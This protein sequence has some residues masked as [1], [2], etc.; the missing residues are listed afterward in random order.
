MSDQS[1]GLAT[2]PGQPLDASGWK[3]Q[4]TLWDGVVLQLPLLPGVFATSGFTISAIGSLGAVLVMITMGIIALLSNFLFAEMAGMFP[5]KPGSLAMYAREG[6]RRYFVP[7]GVLGGFGYWLGYV[8]SVSY[9]ALQFGVLIQFQWFPKST[10][11]VNFVGGV[12][13]GLQHFIA[14]GIIVVA[15][16]LALFD[17]K[18]MARLSTW[19]GIVALI[20]VL[21]IM[22][23]PWV[24]GQAHVSEWTM[25]IGGWKS[26]V[27]WLYIAGATLFAS[28]LGAAFAP[29]YKNPKKD[30]PRV[31]MFSAIFILI[32]Y[33]LA[34]ISASA[35][36]G[37]KTITAN[38]LNFAPI[39]AAQALGGG[40]AIFTAVYAAALGV[41]VLIFINDCARATAGMAED[42][43]SIKQ[44]MNLNRFGAPYVGAIVVAAINICMILFIANPIGIALAGNVGYILA[45]SLANWSY[46]ILRKT[47]PDK[48]RPTKLG[49]AWLPIAVALGCLHILIMGVG[50]LSPGSA[51]YGG[52]KETLIGLGILSVGLIVWI[53]RVTLQDHEPL[54]LRDLDWGAAPVGKRAEEA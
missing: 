22:T 19:V 33:T 20:F 10:W 43:D 30:V 2:P 17:V 36:L 6:F 45:H 50:I 1:A 21:I 39:A 25:H 31:L 51:G 18:I 48:P 9:A 29:E 28:E 34:P 13:L 14:V 54:R 12:H 8:V 53:I 15:L 41:A 4:M 35:Q 26:F 7:A 46:V 52:M 11:T 16:A 49:P 38:P 23:L 40:Q 37:E 27:V 44:L 32:T 42:G 47:Q 3:K 24:R 5:E